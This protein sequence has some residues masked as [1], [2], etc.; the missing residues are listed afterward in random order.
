MAV[1]TTRA[2]F[3][4]FCLRNKYSNWYFNIVENAMARNW[5]R[6][7]ANQYVEKHHIVPRAISMQQK[8]EGDVVF[9]TAREH[10]ICHLLLPKMLVGEDKRKMNF[11]LI[12]LVTG[13]NKNYTKSAVLY[14]KIRQTNSLESSIRS[15]EY[16]ATLSPE[17]R[18]NM[19]TGEKN[20]RYGKPVSQETRTLI[21]N[22]NRGKLSGNKHPLYGVG[23][24]VATKVKMSKNMMGKYVGKLNPAYGK[25]GAATGKKWYNNGVEEKYHLV[26]EQSMDWILGRLRRVTNGSANHAS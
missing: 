19:R 13:N 22:A 7:S 14:E 18:S 15:T 26:G 1:P 17:T 8:N 21:G 6:A 24:S 5:S 9:L 16:W 2:T 10:F 12:R 11:A 25:P 3:K 20:G 4:A 23:H